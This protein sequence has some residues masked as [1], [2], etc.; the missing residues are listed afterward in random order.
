MHGTNQPQP[1]LLQKVPETKPRALLHMHARLAT[2]YKG[3]TPIV[4]IND[5]DI[6]CVS[7]NRFFFSG[8]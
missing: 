7:S 2:Y 6:F 4:Y 5:V 3:I 8:G 1:H